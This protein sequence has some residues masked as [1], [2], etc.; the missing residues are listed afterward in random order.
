MTLQEAI[1]YRG[2]NAATLSTKLG[3]REGDIRRWCRS[4]GLMLLNAVRMQR[5]AQALDC[6]FLVDGDGVE[7][8]LY[9]NGG[10]HD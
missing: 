6:G 7:V 3:V 1:D 10:S 5:I 4:G 8:E 9:G 2:E